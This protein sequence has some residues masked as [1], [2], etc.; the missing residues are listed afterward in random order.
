MATDLMTRAAAY[1]KKHPSLTMPQ[2]VSKVAAA[3]R[4]KKPAAKKKAAPKKKAAVGKAKRRRPARKAA[5]AKV[6]VKIKAGKNGGET[7]RIGKAPGSK[8]V[9]TIKKIGRD[10]G[11]SGI[12]HSKMGTELQH[13]ATLTRDLESHKHKLKQKGHT[14]ADKA[15][16]RRDILHYKNA[17]AASKKHIN[18]L[19]RSL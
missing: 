12:A 6:K 4:A 5:P 2:A 17:I 3:D 18:A 15:R 8:I 11:I 9:R 14:P 7:I 16:I 19:K 13:Q 10:L 1:R